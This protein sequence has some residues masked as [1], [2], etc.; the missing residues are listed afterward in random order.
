MPKPALSNYLLLLQKVKQTLI[1]GQQKIEA[2]KVK[3]YWE[4][5]N[6][7]QTHILAHKDRADYRMEVLKR[8]A[9]DLDIEES[10]LHR[11]LKFFRM[12]PKSKILGGRPKFT[13][14]HYRKLLAISDE[15]ER[16]SWE[17]K[18]IEHAWTADELAAR[19]KTSGVLEE[20][21]NEGRGTKD[22]GRGGKPLISL[23]GKLYTYKLVQRPILGAQKESGILVDLGFGI[24]HELEGR[25]ASRF[26]ADEI[27]E[28][29]VKDN[30]YS[31]HASERTE[32]D[33]FTYQAY[34]EKVVDGDTL[35]VRIDLGFETWVRHYLRLR[36]IDCPE[37]NTKEGAAAKTFVQSHLKEASL[38]VLRSS[39][40]DKYDRYLADV[41]VP[42]GNDSDP[43]SDL[44][45]NNVLLKG[46]LAR[47]MIE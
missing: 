21:E 15:N 6:L 31:F 34:I 1:L 5:G 28:S 9:D 7:I 43:A 44:F 38:I 42:S 25:I 33:L 47:R 22:E 4:T 10:N 37:I 29:K 16:R 41:F 14:T 24:F 2:E 23:R 18:I 8:L 19:I 26:R 40:S 13:W 45:L 12:Y 17:G 36:G 46:G 3:I 30:G 27:I 39:R 11:C 35:K 32:K 20:P